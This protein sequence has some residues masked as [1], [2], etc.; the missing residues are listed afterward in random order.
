[1][2]DR[3]WSPVAAHNRIGWRDTGSDGVVVLLLVLIV[4]VPV[5]PGIFTVDSQSIYRDAIQGSISNWYSPT[6]SWLWGVADHAGIPPAGVLVLATTGVVS[7]LLATYRLLLGRKGARVAT[8][9]TILWPPVYGLLA[10]VG[11]DI[12]FLACLLAVVA[13]LGWATKLP[14]HRCALLAIAGIPAWVALDSRQNGFPVL[15]VWGA[16]AA[17]SLLQGRRW[18]LVAASLAAVT[19]VALGLGVE[20]AARSV[21]VSKWYYPQQHMQ[22][23]DLLNVSLARNESQLPGSLF[24][25]QDLDAV[26][27][28]GVAEAVTG[29]DPLVI[30]RPYDGNAG[31]QAQ[32]DHTWWAMVRKHPL[33]YAQARGRMYL[34]QLMIGR[35]GRATF[36][37]A[38]DELGW[39]LSA[40]L[41]QS[42][43]GLNR[44][45]IDLLQIF[46]PGSPGSGGPLHAV[47]LYVL[48]GM[49]GGVRLAFVGGHA[50]T[51]GVSSLILQVTLQ[52]GV[53]FFAPAVSYRYQLF[54]VVLGIILATA[55]VAILRKSSRHDDFLT[56]TDRDRPVAPSN[57]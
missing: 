26:R 35:P 19:A 54:Q 40:E 31:L 34:R 15:A 44:R 52:G 29:T 30:W 49:A 7:A 9:A 51:L 14:Q 18:R 8:A 1:V 46:E 43:P 37:R 25:S 27:R 39:D 56:G 6:L 21:I 53:F 55:A 3:E 36:F 24:P 5:W 42:F 41:R 16:V 20:S 10:W 50:R 38:S 17:W 28:R 22:Y 4:C 48:L 13:L 33:D 12:W 47:W 23:Q 11:R 57:L 2:A 45:R 32:V